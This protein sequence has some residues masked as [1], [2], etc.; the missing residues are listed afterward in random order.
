MLFG[1]SE[2][3]G[4]VDQSGLTPVS[5]A[6]TAR[7]VKSAT[8]LLSRY[9]VDWR[10]SCAKPGKR[11]ESIPL[12]ESFMIVAVGN[13]SNTTSTT[14]VLLETLTPSAFASLAGKI[15]LWVS[16]KKMNRTR[17]TIGAGVST[18]SSCLT[19]PGL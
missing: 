5:I 12:P 9:Q 8:V 3:I 2:E 10:A 17:K 6:G 1:W 15:S 11:F 7:P 16:L 13:S 14:G 19:K 4:R 18:S